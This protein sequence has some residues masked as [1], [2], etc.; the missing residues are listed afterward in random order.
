M[1]RSPA[2]RTVTVANQEGLHARAATLIADLVRRHE[3]QVKIVKG[4]DRVDAIDVL[5]VLSLGAHQGE[6]LVLE[7]VGDDAET[8]LD[9]LVRLFESLFQ[10]QHTE[11]KHN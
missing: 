7:A 10:S 2:S 9:G 6:V 4:S 8:V 5:Q 3:A 1:C 11:R